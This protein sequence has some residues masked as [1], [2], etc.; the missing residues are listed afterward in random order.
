[1]RAAI[2][3]AVKYTRGVFFVGY[4]PS[5]I[6]S[7]CFSRLALRTILSVLLTGHR[8]GWALLDENVIAWQFW[9][10]FWMHQVVLMV[11]ATLKEESLTVFK[12]HQDLSKKAK[13]SAVNAVMTW[14]PEG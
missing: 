12:W 3:L 11:L 7:G 5:G 6:V 4:H 10:F 13:S 8:S 9:Q 2:L 14:W 1:M